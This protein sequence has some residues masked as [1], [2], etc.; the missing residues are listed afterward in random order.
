[1][2]EQYLKI[3]TEVIENKNL[4]YGAMI[5]YGYI[6]L[7]THKDGYCYANNTYFS[8]L[9]NTS[10]RTVTRL[11]RELTNSQLIYDKYASKRVRNIYIKDKSVY[12][13]RQKCPDSEDKDV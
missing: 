13:Y 2:N 11:L 7:L 8:L 1:M 3:P 5:L 10:K 9:L 4:S 6:V 12:M